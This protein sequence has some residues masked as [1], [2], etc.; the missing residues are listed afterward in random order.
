MR[1]LP[2]VGSAGPVLPAQRHPDPCSGP[3]GAPGGR[4]LLAEEFMREL[5]A[6]LGVPPKRFAPAALQRLQR[7]DWP[8]NVREL[9]NLVERLLIM[10]PGEEVGEARSGAFARR[11]AAPD[12]GDELLPLKA[13]RERFER[14]YIAGMV[15][16]CGGNMSR[17]A[18]LLGL[19]RSHLYR[20]LRALR[21]Y[22]R[23][24]PTTAQR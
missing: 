17:A 19:E 21:G 22:G 18:R 3:G 7:H 23:V 20:K 4:G 16:Q 11:G 10:V 14:D 9:R 15:A 2:P 24:D 12:R 13:A 8:G 6:N 1:R 5:A